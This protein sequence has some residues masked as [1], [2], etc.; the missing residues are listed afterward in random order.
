MHVR[1]APEVDI[2]RGGGGHVG[3][4]TVDRERPRVEDGEVGLAKFGQLLLVRPDQ[5]VVHE[6]RVVGARAHHA[7]LDARLHS[8]NNHHFSPCQ[9][10]YQMYPLGGP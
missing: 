7:H 4:V 2:D 1:A 8:T 5:H 10:V 9:K 3:G 6:Q